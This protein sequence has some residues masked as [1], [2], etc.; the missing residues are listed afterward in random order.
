MEGGDTPRRSTGPPEVVVVSITV[1]EL[2][3]AG[4]RPLRGRLGTTR[5]HHRARIALGMVLALA[6]L[7][8]MIVLG[9]QSNRVSRPVG[10]GRA[11]VPAGERRAIAAALGYPYPPRCLTITILDSRVDYARANV[12][13]ANGCGRYRGY[14]NASLGRVDGVWRLVLDEG[15][16]FVPNSLL[17]PRVAGVSRRS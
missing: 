9:A 15:Q 14:V 7:A 11:R 17:V 2:P 10:G 3:P 6:A 5:V 8:A 16:L 1:T 4:A 13:R 12:D